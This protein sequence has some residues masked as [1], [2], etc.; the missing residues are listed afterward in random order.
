MSPSLTLRPLPL[1]AWPELDR[2]LWQI[3]SKGP[4]FASFTPAYIQDVANGYG[5]W[6]SLLA[7]YSG[8]DSETHP[9]DRVTLV[10]VQT[11]LAALGAAGKKRSTIVAYLC[12]LRAA[13]QIMVPERSHTWLHARKV[14]RAMVDAE[15][16]VENNQ[17]ELQG[18]PVGDQRLWQAGLQV[19]DILM[20]PQYASRLRAATVETIAAGYRRWLI[21][22]REEGRL[23]TDAQPADRVTRANV[24][25]YIRAL[26]RSQR[27]TSILARVSELRTALQIMQSD[28]D[29]RWLISPGGRSLSSW[30][31]ATKRSLQ[32]PDS[33]FLYKWGKTMMQE[34]LAEANPEQRRISYR[35]G[36]LIAVFASRAP[37][38]LSMAS[39]R[40]GSTVIRNG[41]AYRLVFE[42]EDVKTGRCIEYDA[43]LGLSSAIDR[44][45]SVERTEL[46]SK[47]T[48]EWLWVDQYGE[49]LSSDNISDMIQRQSKA[50]LGFAFG[51]H[52]FRHALGTTAPLKDP[53]HPGVA[54]AI[55][56]ISGRMVEEHYN[57]ASRADVADRFHAA[58]SKERA[59]L[60]SLARREFRHQRTQTLS[61]DSAKDAQ[62]D[63]PAQKEAAGR[64]GAAADDPG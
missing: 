15:L 43:P 4:Y 23:D 35:N 14:F 25:G 44:Y 49:P 10:G 46:L 30:L 8:L 19:D 59:N 48:H 12:Y 13:L 40:L 38:V 36:L 55:L 16:P 56:G 50:C 64:H 29:F 21:F 39:L 32:V 5:R 52:R 42:K 28:A 60:Q 26:R 20:G 62:K 6:L 53:A 63:P 17:G 22:L 41:R 18:W 9:A 2:R 24:V 45:I 27:N 37:R 1:T 54:A 61:C 58:L 47:K 51:P 11:Y 33:D 31:P 57:R 3:A 7:Q 34:A